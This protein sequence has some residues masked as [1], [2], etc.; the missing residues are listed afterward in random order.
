MGVV[1]TA[2]FAA[3][4]LAA[5]TKLAGSQSHTRPGLDLAVAAEEVAGQELA[6]A[7]G[8]AVVAAAAGWWARAVADMDD[9]QG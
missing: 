9:I 1:A 2:R 7:A 8:L 5:E 4:N 3:A 6:I